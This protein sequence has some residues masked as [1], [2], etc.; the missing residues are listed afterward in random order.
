M[1]GKYLKNITKSIGLASFDALKEMNPVISNSIDSNKQ[2]VADNFKAVKE[3]VK[4]DSGLKNTEYYKTSKNLVK[5]A[6]R[7]LKSGEIYSANTKNS[8]ENAVA[9]HLNIDMNQFNMDWDDL[10]DMDD[11]EVKSGSVTSSSSDFSEDKEETINENNVDIT[12]NNSRTYNRTITNNV[13][14]SQNSNKA[15]NK[16]LSSSS[17]AMLES[18]RHSTSA[19]L[20][21]LNTLSTFQ[22]E[23]TVQFYNDVSS[24]LADIGNTLNSVKEMFVKPSS[25]NDT[26][27]Y[28]SE[29]EDFL[30][31]SLDLDFYKRKA[32]KGGGGFLDVLKEDILPVF[33]TLA[34]NPLGFAMKEGIKALMPK[35]FKNSMNNLNSMMETLPI[36][37]QFMLGRWKNSDNGLKRMLSGMFGINLNEKAKLKFGN[38]E[39]GS[40]PFDGI[41]K[42]AITNTIPSLLAKILASVSDNPYYQQELVYDYEKGKFTTKEMIRKY[43]KNEVR[44]K[45]IEHNMEDFKRETLKRIGGNA[46]SK[47]LEDVDIAI[48]KLIDNAAVP[49]SAKLEDISSN[50]IVAKAIKDAYA[51]GSAMDRANYKKNLVE[52]IQ[53]RNNVYSDLN[54]NF[55]YHNAFDTDYEMIENLSGKK[56]KESAQEQLARYGIRKGSLLYKFVDNQGL[57]SAGEATL[58]SSLNPFNIMAKAIDKFTT[59]VDNYLLKEDSKGDATELKDY[60]DDVFIT[61]DFEGETKISKGKKS[62]KKGKTEIINVIRDRDS[63]ITEI[64][65]NI[66]NVY[67]STINTYDGQTSS[68]SQ[69]TSL[70]NEIVNDAKK[71]AVEEI[72]KDNEVNTNSEL[73]VDNQDSLVI[74]ANPSG[75]ASIKLKGRNLFESIK[76]KIFNP[77]KDFFNDKIL[78]PIKNGFKKAK[79]YLM[80]TII[81]PIKE[82]FKPVKDRIKDSVKGWFSKKAKRVGGWFSKNFLGGKTFKDYLLGVDEKIQNKVGKIT[83]RISGMAGGD[84]DED[85]I[86]QIISE[87][88]GEKPKENKSFVESTKNAINEAVS[89]GK[90]GINNIKRYVLKN[91]KEQAEEVINEPKASTVDSTNTEHPMN[92]EITN[93]DKNVEH[94]KNTLDDFYDAFLASQGV[95]ES[96]MPKDRKSRN[97]GRF[98]KIKGWVSSKFNTLKDMIKNPFKTI[99]DKFKKVFDPFKKLLDIPKKIGGFFKGLFGDKKEGK[100]G[101]FGVVKNL[102]K[103]I[104]GIGNTIKNTFESIFNDARKIGKKMLDGAGKLID[105]AMS[106]TKAIYEDMKAVGK[107]LWGTA[108]SAVSTVWDRF[109]GEGSK[110]SGREK[111]MKVII[112]GGYLDG[113]KEPVTITTKKRSSYEEMKQKYQDEDVEDDALQDSSKKAGLFSHFRNNS[114]MSAFR[115]RVSGLLGSVKDGVVDWAK[116]S[117]VGRFMAE[118]KRKFTTALANNQKRGILGSVGR[119]VGRWM[120]N[121]E[122]IENQGMT[123]VY[124]MGSDIPMGTN[125]SDIASNIVDGLTGGNGKKD[126]FFFRMFEK[127]GGTKLGQKFLGTKAGNFAL[128]MMTSGRGFW[129]NTKDLITKG[130]NLGIDKMA[131]TKIGANILDMLTNGKG[132][133]GN[134]GTVMGKVSGKLGNFAGLA[135]DGLKALGGLGGVAGTAGSLLGKAGKLAGKFALPLTIAMGAF[136]GIKGWKNANN[137]FETEKATLGQKLSSGAGS[138]LSGLTLGLLKEDTMAKGIHKLGTGI[139]NLIP[140]VKRYREN[141]QNERKSGFTK[142]HYIDQKREAEKK[143]EESEEKMSTDKN[144]IEELT[145]KAKLG[146]GVIPHVSPI[147]FQGRNLITAFRYNKKKEDE[148]EKKLLQQMSPKEREAYL[149]SKTN[150]D[151]LSQVKAFSPLFGMLGMLGKGLGGSPTEQRKAKKKESWFK[152]MTTNISNMLGL[153]TLTNIEKSGKEGGIFSNMW[154]SIKSFFGFGDNNSSGGSGGSSGGSGSADGSIL[155]IKSMKDM[156]KL[157]AKY[158]VGFD[159]THGRNKGSGKISN[160]AGDYGGKS[161]G[162]PQF[163]M[164]TGSLEGFVNSLKTTAPEIY[165]QLARHPLGSS[166][167]DEAWYRVAEQYGDRFA[168]LQSDYS[169]TNYYDVLK[170]NLKNKFGLDLDKRSIA[171]NALAYSTA[172]QYGPYQ[173]SEK[174]FRNAINRFGGKVDSIS[175]ENLI[176]GVQKSKEDNIHSDFSSSS[177]DIRQGVL[178]RITRER[179]DALAILKSEQSMSNGG[180]GTGDAILASARSQL[181]VPYVWGGTTPGKG[182]DC[183]GL[184]QYAH[185]ANGIDISRT[186]YTQVKEGQ[187]VSQS[188][189]Q[190]G[191][192][193]FS[194]WSNS[195]TPEHVSIYAGNS[196]IIHAPK[197]G[198][199]VKESGLPSGRLMFRRLYGG[200]RSAMNSTRSA[201]GMEQE[202]GNIL[203]A[204]RS[205][206]SNGAK[207]T[208]TRSVSRTSTYSAENGGSSFFSTVSN[209]LKSLAQ[210]RTTTNNKVSD[211]TINSTYK[212]N[213][214]ESRMNKFTEMVFILNKIAENTSNISTTNS[215]LEKMI[216]V[217][218]DNNKEEKLAQVST[219]SLANANNPF[220]NGIDRDIDLLATGI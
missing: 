206:M 61:N 139:T 183:S 110:K 95:P 1:A 59:S 167:F 18:N 177:S 166:G 42:R 65:S 214:D 212:A 133:F 79:D 218:K 47:T 136:D 143:L 137:I 27:L 109:F 53:S 207:A 108:K 28:N 106:A 210:T 88:T 99:S 176:I 134:A 78:T 200:A 147:L 75:T 103:G 76:D 150:T 11:G 3:F 70:K 58:S 186:T 171:L 122:D 158:E 80:D 98:G 219:Q 40:I 43:V 111:A 132:F 126:S 151:V 69:L 170:K 138:I 96:D 74:E 128:D 165:S 119:A 115:E 124:I 113:I 180:G 105:G 50:S 148:A 21:S 116:N 83:A 14:M 211:S 182:L 205:S 172:I 154:N 10:D 209:R 55:S 187:E 175:D 25:E 16:I 202:E 6:L 41:T 127:F 13:I 220:I 216:E 67:G 120:S 48:K 77:I 146:G 66:V 215:L 2:F 89:R 156:W 107:E 56:K 91:G 20:Q 33:K 140:G 174:H 44:D 117:R 39:K 198:D 102:F 112:D 189:A 29:L 36:S 157:S 164:T 68:Q 188:S 22:N 23:T 45:S 184:T 169:K 217:L 49:E 199:V 201:L 34:S 60:T 161:Y 17:R 179:D 163:S 159:G 191:D 81:N 123:P 197:P 101:L 35:S 73:S 196:K 142:L 114:R 97:G 185:K 62:R 85:I 168:Q 135:D 208:S 71:Q 90:T 19:L 178:N 152:K 104:K 193:I 94:I 145:S 30:M 129:G 100:K 121:P 24:K 72:A 51:Q 162:I 192:L 181:G 155:G 125:G 31:N 131:N 118:K 173:L 92:K 8:I 52:A 12:N 160:N 84:I 213:T 46:D 57:F 190:P 82:A 87:E 54:K 64:K 144:G 15:T 149:A 141:K 130:K 5:N 32:Q 7:E 26:D 37:L 9:E 38:Y 63:E 93:I 86:E 153:N 4:S 194:N 204:I 195:T 203:G